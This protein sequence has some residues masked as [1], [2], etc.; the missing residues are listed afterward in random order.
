MIATAR[1][2]LL[3]VVAFVGL[4]SLFA[5]A[6]G[7][8]IVFQPGRWASG[9]G[10]V[11]NLSPLPVREIELSAK[12]GTKLFAWHLENPAA[13]A[14][15]LFLHGNAGHIG[16]RIDYLIALQKLPVSIFLLDYRGYGKSEG[17]PSEEGLYEDAEAAC[18]WLHA[19]G[20]TPERLFLYG[21]SLG[22][23]VAIETASR[24]PVAGLILQATFTSV[25]D[26]A[27]RMIPFLPLGWAIRAKFENLSKIGSIA[28]PKL[29]FHGLPDEVVPHELGKRLFS[30]AASPKRWVEYADMR[31]NEWPGAREKQWLE[32]IR[33][34]L[35][36]NIPD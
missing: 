15:I 22:G 11:R 16:H 8:R 26:M 36:E 13:K 30:A 3:A 2:L 19:R 17:T 1:I 31:H 5:F 12:D 9:D 20:V 34:F 28:A 14:T 32:E 33:R 29:H 4:L 24:R 7:N 10:R 18:D 25:G 21:E 35:G 6:F 23:A 27:R